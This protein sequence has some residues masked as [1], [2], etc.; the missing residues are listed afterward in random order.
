MLSRQR[1][2][3]LAGDGCRGGGRRRRGGVRAVQVS[4]EARE[5][6]AETETGR[7]RGGE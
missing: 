1:R 2:D 6:N 3:R 7:R 5:S 4:R